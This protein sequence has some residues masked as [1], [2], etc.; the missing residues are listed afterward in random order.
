MNPFLC[1]ASLPGE[2]LTQICWEIVGHL[3]DHL[4]DLDQIKAEIQYDTPSLASLCRTSKRLRDIVTPVLYFRFTTLRGAE[5]AI[6]FLVAISQ[7]QFLGLCVRKLDLCQ[8]TSMDKIID[9]RIFQTTRVDGQMT[10]AQRQI[11]NE[12]ATRLDID[13]A[14]IHLEQFATIVQL[15]LAYTPLVKSVHIA[16]LLA[17]T[18]DD[19]WG[20]T[21]LKRLA[22]QVP[23]RVSL[24]YLR[25]LYLE[26][27]N[28][29]NLGSSYSL[30]Y[31]AGIFKL[32][33][34]IDTLHMDPCSG[35]DLPQFYLPRRITTRPQVSLANVTTLSLIQGNTPSNAVKWMVR[36]CAQL[37]HFQ[38]YSSG[39]PVVNRVTPKEIIHVLR[40][41][42][43]SLLSL[44][45]LLKAKSTRDF[46]MG[47]RMPPCADGEQ[48]VSLKAFTKLEILE[49][50]APSIR[51]PKA[52]T[53]GYHTHVLNEILPQSIKHFRFTTPQKECI[54]NLKTVADYRANRFP[55]L[56]SVYL[57]NSSRVFPEE[58]AFDTNEMEAVRDRLLNAGVR[59]EY[60][61]LANS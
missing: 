27:V 9:Q 24:D 34:S 4:G 25:N 46:N 33:P 1:L 37:K 13:E 58:T 6:P 44:S 18:V 35:I 19:R 5:R 2:I 14:S 54:P 15:I 26:H 12:A 53:P 39:Y 29:M 36:D 61:E 40:L 10:E 31:F 22:A 8:A 23:R 59:F 56:R 52:D 51:F 49:L 32:A 16:T 21:I 3:D 42:K 55:H 28:D 60:V 17:G 43:D 38:Y 11:L 57:T 48:I 47:I 7:R 45:L 20:Y 41:H 30:Q 50:N